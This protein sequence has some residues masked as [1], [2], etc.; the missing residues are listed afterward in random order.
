MSKQEW[1]EKNRDA[2]EE[3]Y[4][5]MV[6]LYIEDDLADWDALKSYEQA[7]VQLGILEKDEEICADNDD[8]DTG[9]FWEDEE[10]AII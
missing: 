8:N 1:I 10:W 9:A 6:M 5:E 2:L 7:L 4:H 3:K